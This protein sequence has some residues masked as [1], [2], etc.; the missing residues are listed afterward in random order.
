MTWL[1]GAMVIVF[2]AVATIVLVLAVGRGALETAV[3][4][5]VVTAL[6]AAYLIRARTRPEAVRRDRRTGGE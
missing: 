2:C 4:A 6:V 5:V 3:F 1:R